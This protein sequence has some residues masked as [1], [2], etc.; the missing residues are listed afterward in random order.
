MQR[1]IQTEF[2]SSRFG[3]ALSDF[4]E[5]FPFSIAGIIA[6]Q[7]DELK[8]AI[9]EIFQRERELRRFSRRWIPHSLSEARK[10]NRTAIAIDLSSV[11]HRQANHSFSRIATGY[12]SW[13]FYL[14]PSDHM[15]AAIRDEVIPSEKAMIRPRKLFWR[16]SSAV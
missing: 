9:K 15:F 2:S 6:Q 1:P 10:A 11:L 3:K 7:F 12:E 8:H 16:F 4:L 5:E 13:F 14:Y